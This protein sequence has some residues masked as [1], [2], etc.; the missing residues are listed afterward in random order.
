[1]IKILDLGVTHGIATCYEC[2]F[3]DGLGVSK[4][5]S[6]KKIKNRYKKH[7][8]ETGHNVTL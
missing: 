2:D 5:D 3:Y 4:S 8:K 6:L 7:F 1:M